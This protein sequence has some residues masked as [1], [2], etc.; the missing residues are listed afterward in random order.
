[1]AEPYSE[2]WSGLMREIFKGK[3]R[4]RFTRYVAAYG[5]KPARS[6]DR[7]RMRNHERMLSRYA[8]VGAN[9]TVTH[10]IPDYAVAVEIPAKVV[11]YLDKEKFG[12]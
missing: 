7:P 6:D 4:R 12:G 9:S 1:M 10:D 11:K 8:I 3:N 2:E 5:H